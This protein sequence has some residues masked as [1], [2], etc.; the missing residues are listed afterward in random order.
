VIVRAPNKVQH[1]RPTCDKKRREHS[2][3]HQSRASS[4]ADVKQIHAWLDPAW[5]ER[6]LRR[7]ERV[8]FDI[9]L[10]DTSRCSYRSEVL[11]PES[12]LLAIC[13]YIRDAERCSRD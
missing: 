10:P 7:I 6:Q 13:S 4:A 5:M 1:R 11:P 12:W 8:A 3:K 9:R 2:L